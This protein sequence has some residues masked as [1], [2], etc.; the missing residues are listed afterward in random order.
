MSNILEGSHIEFAAIESAALEPTNWDRWVN[1][2]EKAV[3]HDLDGDDSAEARANGTADG[4][5]L[6]GAYD[7]WRGGLTVAQY[8]AKVAASKA[9]IA[10][11]AS[12]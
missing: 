8:A 7:A 3:G 1:R 6:D 12:A 10:A 5:S 2:A 11:G 9:R 4:Y